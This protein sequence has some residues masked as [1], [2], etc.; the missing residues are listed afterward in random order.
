MSDHRGWF[1][2][3]LDLPFPR[4]GAGDCVKGVM[5][6]GKGISLLLVLI[7]L[8]LLAG[9]G[10][11]NPKIL[12]QREAY[13]LESANPIEADSELGIE[14]KQL[15]VPTAALSIFR[16][17]I[18]SYLWIRAD[19]LKNDGEYF[20]ALT[21]RRTICALMPHVPSVWVNQ[22]WDMSY[23]ISVG[24]PTPQERWRWVMAGVELLRS[25]G[26]RYNPK[27][28]VITRELGWIFQHKIGGISDDYHLYY[29]ARLAYEMMAIMGQD[30][31]D[32]ERLARLAAA[33]LTWEELKQNADVVKLM[34]ILRKAQP[35]WDTDE[36]LEEGLWRY[37][38][39]TLNRIMQWDKYL[40]EEFS[41]ELLGAIQQQL[42]TEAMNKL[43]TFMRARQLRRVWKMDPAFMLELNHKYGP[44]DYE[45]EQQANLSLD[46][47]L[48]WAHSLY[49]GARGLTYMDDNDF[50]F[51]AMNLHRLVYHSLQ[52]MFHEGNLYVQSLGPPPEMPER[53]PGQEVLEKDLYTGQ[54]MVINTEDLR[55]FPIA[56]QATLDILEAHKL[57]GEKEPMGVRDGS[58]NL[59]KAGVV[60]LFMA[61]H[62]KAAGVYFTKLQQRVPDDPQYQTDLR[63]F[64]Q[65][66]VKKEVADI[67]PKNARNYI[68]S[69]L[70]QAFLDYASHNDDKSAA[71]EEKARYVYEEYHRQFPNPEDRIAIDYPHLRDTA[72][73]DFL[74]DPSI[75]PLPKQLLLDRI[76][77]DKPELYENLRAWYLEQ[78][79]PPNGPTAP[80]P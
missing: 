56:Y 10:L 9:A 33:P 68:V 72:L 21:L 36:A 47:R 62:T 31:V 61:G 27:D 14:L 18:I 78:K 74:L 67:S 66:Y 12:R 64:V 41:P 69:F 19:T 28:P 11:L 34:E 7:G 23:N 1:Y 70:R 57:A 59:C 53:Q 45:S 49:W 40:E 52:E 39:L 63:S 24:L 60:N 79:G 43:Q 29:K 73:K 30:R 48:P 51:K 22:A 54:L 76:A 65:E 6:T 46:W 50:T 80:V 38:R 5:R 13:K 44:V 17:I 32:N 15:R 25:E 75:Y 37:T 77:I 8:V 26:L 2:R 58:I 20:D 4:I 55:M 3:I 42:S 16:P 35:D 71:A